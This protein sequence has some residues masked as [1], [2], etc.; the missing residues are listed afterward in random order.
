MN[1]DA[2]RSRQGGAALLL[3]LLA[4]TLAFSVA[5]WRY[6]SSD[7]LR[8]QKMERTVQALATA[9]AALLAR[10]AMDDNRPGSLPCPDIDNDG[11]ANGTV[12]NDV[13]EDELYIGRFPHRTLEMDDLRDGDGER[14]WYALSPNFRDADGIDIN[15]TT[16]SEINLN[17]DSETIAVV[18]SAGKP[19]AGQITRSSNSVSDYLESNPAAD[20]KTFIAGNITENFNDLAISIRK[21][22]WL[23][24]IAPRILDL[25]RGPDNPANSGNPVSGLR[26]YHKDHGEF[27]A[28]LST[29]GIVYDTVLTN[30]KWLDSVIDDYVY[31]SSNPWVNVLAYKKHSANSATL[32]LGHR[33]LSIIPPVTP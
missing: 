27:P 4:L 9:K 8:N 5:A 6:F 14:L 23:K 33:S 24:L 25:V 31:D 22:E 11:T 13:C 28:T 30:N 21:D 3:L 19:L 32:Y 26:A 1:S 18:F 20:S 12:P 7:M 17:G 10:A 15:S 16:P 2:L 29:S